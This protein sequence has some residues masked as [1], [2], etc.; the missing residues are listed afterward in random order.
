M[1]NRE[2][3]ALRLAGACYKRARYSLKQDG[4]GRTLSGYER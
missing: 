3:R 4:A 2:A 1:N